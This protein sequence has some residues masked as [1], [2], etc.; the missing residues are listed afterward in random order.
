MREFHGNIYN[1]IA[2]VGD[3]NVVPDVSGVDIGDIRAS[4][5][6]ASTVASSIKPSPKLS[7]LTL[8]IITL[9]LIKHPTAFPGP[10][11]SEVDFFYR[12]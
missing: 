9:Q 4:G 1:D 8:T 7:L 2:V 11:G 5:I 6:K 10:L 3:M 12:V